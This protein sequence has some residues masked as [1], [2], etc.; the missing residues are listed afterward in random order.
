[1]GSPSGKKK[2]ASIFSHPPK[3]KVLALRRVSEC[4]LNYNGHRSQ[5]SVDRVGSDASL[6]LKQPSTGPTVPKGR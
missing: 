1:M 6:G 2:V 5:T 3:S 4:D